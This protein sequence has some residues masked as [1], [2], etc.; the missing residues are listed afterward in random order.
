[1]SAPVI[2]I[3]FPLAVSAAILL[4]EK[5]PGL[6]K[7]SGL[8]VS[9]FLTLMAILQPIGSVIKLGP[10]SVDLTSNLG[11]FGRELILVNS[12]RFTLS[13]VFM[14]VT[15]F[16]GFFDTTNLPIKFISLSLATAALL[17][18]ALAVQPFLYSAVLIELAIL[19]MVP[20]V[21]DKSNSSQKGILNFVIYQTLAMPL[22]LFSGWILGG[23]QASPSDQLRLSMAAFFLIIGFALWLA[24][25]PF[26]SW[27]PQFSQAVHPYFSGFVFSVLPVVTILIMVDY[28]SSLVWL[29]ESSFL[30]PALRGVG[31]IMIVT[32]GIWSAVEK[33]LKRVLAYSVLLETGFALLLISLQSNEGL[34][35]LYQSFIPRIF[36]LFVMVLSLSVLLG[37]GNQLSLQGIK[38]IIK[39]YPFSSAG[40]VVSMLS[41]SG[42][43]LF[44]GFPVKLDTIRLIGQE[45]FGSVIWILIGVAGYLFAVIRVFSSITEPD[46][47]NLKVQETVPQITQLIAGILILL[48]MGWI[49][50]LITAPLNSVLNYLPLLK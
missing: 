25:F 5:K 50:R 13:L 11:F 18:A 20:M 21:V 34:G 40:L 2:W 35:L 46:N 27:V 32:A 15:L 12:D 42:L 8:L 10:I 37:S 44:A 49:P 48:L 17:V 22:I 9:I 33:D 24:V 16:V 1:M 26:H 31:I 47:E 7:V 14:A 19:L 38:S 45:S 3:L 4:L 6:V 39:R 30:S 41:V 28:V 23:I 29:R 43:P 36:G